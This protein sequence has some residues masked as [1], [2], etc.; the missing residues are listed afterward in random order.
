MSDPLSEGQLSSLR[1]WCGSELI[2]ID[3]F[4]VRAEYRF[5]NLGKQP[6]LAL[7]YPLGPITSMEKSTSI[8]PS[9]RRAF[10]VGALIFAIGGF[11][12]MIYGLSQ[13]WGDFLEG[14]A[15]LGLAYL[16]FRESRKDSHA[17]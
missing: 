7:V 10:L 4:P 14:V 16:A 17:A 3:T 5:M 15:V 1:R 12:M 13:G 2:E 6:P 8:S 11:A 9:R